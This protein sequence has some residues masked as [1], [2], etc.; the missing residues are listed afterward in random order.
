MP[1]AGK[2]RARA[3]SRS[4]ATRSAAPRYFERPLAPAPT[5]V[6][7]SVVAAV[8]ILLAVVAAAITNDWAAVASCTAVIGLG[9]AALDVAGR[10]RAT[11]EPDSLYTAQRLP[12]EKTRLKPAIVSLTLLVVVFYAGA[13]VRPNIRPSPLPYFLAGAFLYL[14]LPQ[15]LARR[16]LRK[17]ATSAP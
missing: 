14:V 15:L 6:L 1:K 10:K 3:N 2:V 16:V 12:S 13:T 5:P 4:A 7:G 8:A 11:R 17:R 9:A